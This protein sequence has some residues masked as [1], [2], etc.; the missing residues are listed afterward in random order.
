MLLLDFP[1][2]LHSELS[3]T[4]VR[5]HCKRKCIFI[6]NHSLTEGNAQVF[7]LAYSSGPASVRRLVQIGD[8]Q[9]LQPQHSPPTAGDDTGGAARELPGLVQLG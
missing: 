7:T 5:R 3:H 1:L 2:I 8:S 9:A 6:S 4:E